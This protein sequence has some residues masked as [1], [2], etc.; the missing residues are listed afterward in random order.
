MRRVTRIRILAPWLAVA[1]LLLGGCSVASL[2]YGVAPTWV[3]W[4]IDGFLSL[5]RTQKALVGQRLDELQRWHRQTQLP[6]YAGLLRELEEESVAGPL[7]AGRMA[8]WRSVAT[9]ELWPA[10]GDRRP[11]RWPSCC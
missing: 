9:D 3:A 1:A 8:H 7:S 2:G 6:R 11:R 4:E 5:D 10:L